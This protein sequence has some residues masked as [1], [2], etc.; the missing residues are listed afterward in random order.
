MKPDE[1]EIMRTK[2]QA[3]A[4]NLIGRTAIAA[5]IGGALSLSFLLREADIFRMAADGASQDGA[6]LLV[7]VSLACIFAIGAGIMGVTSLLS[8]EQS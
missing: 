1:G 3:V 6:T 5:G 2:S 7:T 8:D 4:R